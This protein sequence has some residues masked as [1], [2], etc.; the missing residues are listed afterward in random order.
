MEN[1]IVPLG[2]INF[3]NIFTSTLAIPNFTPGIYEP[4]VIASSDSYYNK[5][6]KIKLIV[7]SSPTR[8]IAIEY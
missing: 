4:T 1:S 3:I 6:I 2:A 8:T 5:N 7:D